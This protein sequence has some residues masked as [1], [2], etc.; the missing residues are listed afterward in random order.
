[1]QHQ[2][3]VTAQDDT[4]R[5]VFRD[6][7]A[8]PRWV[9]FETTPGFIVTQIWRTPGTGAEPRVSADPALIQT[10]FLPEP[11]GTCLLTVQFPP[12]AVMASVADPQAMVAEFTEKLPGL[13][14]TFEPDSPGMHRTATVDNGILL[15]G[16]LWLELDDGAARRLRP[17]DV[18]IQNATRHAWRNKSDGPAVMAFSMIGCRSA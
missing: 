8:Q 18:V 16:E 9:I 4:G 12:D 3:I 7:V 11:G 10:S 5:S 6:D 17:G 14:D 2:R 1:M 13:F 15:S